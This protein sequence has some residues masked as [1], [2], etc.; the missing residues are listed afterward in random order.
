[1]GEEESV[2]VVADSFEE[3]LVGSDVGSRDEEEAQVYES[4]NRVS[5]DPNEGLQGG[6][7]VTC[8]KPNTQVPAQTQQ[9]EGGPLGKSR[10]WEINSSNKQFQSVEQ[11]GSSFLGKKLG[12]KKGKKR[13]GSPRHGSKSGSIVRGSEEGGGLERKGGS[14]KE[15]S[16]QEEGGLTGKTRVSESNSNYKQDSLVEHQDSSCRGKE[17]RAKKDKE[18]EGYPRDGSRSVSADCGSEEGS[19]VE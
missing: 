10:G 11:Q 4:Q 2:E 19:G 18:H 13:E 5:S 8:S 12:A 15:G 14:S 16:V 1:M 17:L 6:A 9:E 7:K 3:C